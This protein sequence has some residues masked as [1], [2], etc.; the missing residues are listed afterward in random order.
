LPQTSLHAYKEGREDDVTGDLEKLKAGH[1]EDIKQSVLEDADE[2]RDR[3][4]KK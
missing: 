3:V 1:R 2:T 4:Q